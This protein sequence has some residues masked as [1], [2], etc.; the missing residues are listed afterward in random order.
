VPAGIC[1]QRRRKRKR[2]VNFQDTSGFD[3]DPC[4]FG[5]GEDQKKLFL[6]ICSSRTLASREQGRALHDR[7]RAGKPQI[8]HARAERKRS[9][10]AVLPGK[11]EDK[12]ACLRGAVNGGAEKENGS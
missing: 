2:I 7:N 5:H 4:H 11:T 6:L 12:L 3:Q 8:M 1:E 9:R 10:A